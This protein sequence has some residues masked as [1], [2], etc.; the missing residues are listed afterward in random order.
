MLC[1][2]DEENVLRSLKRLFMDEEY[3]IL[4]AASGYGANA[5]DTRMTKRVLSSR[6]TRRKIQLLAND[7]SFSWLNQL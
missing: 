4:T 3:E 2:D 7:A 6:F 5:S 1:V